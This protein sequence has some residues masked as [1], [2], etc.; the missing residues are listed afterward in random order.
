[1][2]GV[3]QAGFFGHVRE[4]A[5]AIVAIEDVLA[6]IGEEKIVEAVVVV[7][8]DADSGSPADLC[9]AG[10]F[11]DVGEG[12]VAIVF[13]EP[14][15]GAGRI[16]FEARA[17]EGEDIEPTVVIVIDKSAAAADG[18]EDVRAV[19]FRAVDQRS[20]ETGLVGNVGEAGIEGDAGGL[21]AGLRLSRRA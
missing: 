17:R 10:F 3:Q 18:F 2:T 5:I 7:I 11:G 9:Q 19:I 13:V 1:L 8:A 21:A 12:A 4:R 6:P 15:G 20:V 16:A 14:V